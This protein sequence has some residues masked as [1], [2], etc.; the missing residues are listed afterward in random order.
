MSS[1]PNPSPRLPPADR[2][3]EA[4]REL[5]GTIVV[6]DTDA[7]FIY[8]GRL[9]GADS[10]FLRLGQVD[11]HEIGK[12][13]LSKERYVH[14]AR[15]IGVRSNRKCTWVNLARVLSISRLED[16]LTF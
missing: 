2:T 7:P 1:N 9:E 3:P 14:E 5:L 13:S 12:A 8:L 16:V 10:E 15:N 11:A 6:V 4:L